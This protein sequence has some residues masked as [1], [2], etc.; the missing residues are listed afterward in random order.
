MSAHA[1]ARQT[2]D[3]MRT[4]SRPDMVYVT[5]GEPAVADALRLRIERELH[6]AAR[7][8]DHGEK[9]TI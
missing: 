9:V 2:I 1:D 3:W 5:H 7:V 8:P 4:G 6:C